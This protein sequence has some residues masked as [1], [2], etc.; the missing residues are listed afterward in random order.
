MKHTEGTDSYGGEHL[1]ARRLFYH[2]QGEV[3]SLTPEME[4]HLEGCAF[5]RQHLAFTVR[6]F[7]QE[8]DVTFETEEFRRLLENDERRTTFPFSEAEVLA[9]AALLDHLT[10]E[11]A[12]R[13]V[14]GLAHELAERL[15][16]RMG[17]FD[18]LKKP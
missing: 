16:E 15:Y 5:C 18:R 12:D 2:A 3:G 17:T 7:S 13:E 10:A 9:M 1:S 11:L 6:T 14:R 8:E 4:A